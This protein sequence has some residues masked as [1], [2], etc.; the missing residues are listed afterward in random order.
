MEGLIGIAFND[1][2]LMAADKTMAY[3][4]I[5][6]KHDQKKMFKLS[7][8][9]VMGVNG[10]PGDTEQFA[11][12]I[13]KNIQLYKMRNGFELSPSSAATFIQR[14]LA[15]SLRSRSAYHVNLLLAGFDEKTGAS[16]YYMD[17]LATMSKL[18]YALHG[19][20]GFFSTSILDR[21]YRPDCSLEEGLDLLKKT[22][23][24]IQKRLIINMPVFSVVKIDKDGI[25]NL[26]DIKVNVENLNL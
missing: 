26:S 3:S 19:Y 9:L 17:Y 20:G 21:S 24:E 5:A 7:D 18:P 12:Y 16:L 2:I 22:I 10:E 4:I 13:E 8:H 6:V 25:T 1:F 14:N 15:D 11:E 23:A